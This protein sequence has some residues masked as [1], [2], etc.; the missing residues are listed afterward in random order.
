MKKVSHLKTMKMVDIS[1]DEADY[2]SKLCGGGYFYKMDDGKIIRFSAAGVV[3][4]RID[5]D[6]VVLFEDEN[7]TSERIHEKLKENIAKE[8]SFSMSLSK[9]DL[10][11][12]TYNGVQERAVEKIMQLILEFLMK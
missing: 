11:N 8:V 4:Y 2:L 7:S 10:S 3:P 5:I 9:H 1:T 6:E 12:L